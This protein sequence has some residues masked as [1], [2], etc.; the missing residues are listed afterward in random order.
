MEKI[1]DAAADSLSNH[2]GKL[3]MTGLDEISAAAAE[4]LSRLDETSL[5][6]G[7]RPANQVRILRRN[8][9]RK[10]D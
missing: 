8:R 5:E 3:V 1:S 7:G 2:K 10:S 4:S 6:L 9:Q